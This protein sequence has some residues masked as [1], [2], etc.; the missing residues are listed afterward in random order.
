M[1]LVRSPILVVMCAAFA[2]CTGQ[3]GGDDDDAPITVAFTSPTPGA[4]FTRDQLGATGELVALVDTQL[5]I[6]GSPTRVSLGTAGAE[7]V[8]ADAAGHAI[9]PLPAAGAVSLTAI[10]YD[11]GGAVAAQATVDIQVGEPAA[12]DCH[13]WLDLYQVAY[14]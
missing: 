6:E 14:E 12:A 10:A 2:G 5:A 9:V 1:G 13:A 3:T 8:D 11:A 4:A 7:L